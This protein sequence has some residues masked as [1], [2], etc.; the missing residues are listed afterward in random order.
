MET[1]VGS[2]GAE[3]IK[4][5]ALRYPIRCSRIEELYHDY[6]EKTGREDFVGFELT[7]LRTQIPLYQDKEL[8]KAAEKAQQDGYEYVI[9]TLKI[10]AETGYRIISIVD[11]LSDADY[12]PIIY[13]KLFG[14][15]IE[16]IEV[17]K[18]NQEK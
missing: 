9:E 10:G 4:N 6:I 16:R 5:L 3:Q 2:I 1:G 8:H 14:K 15:S 18:Y 17:Y 12:A 7:S 11:L 13:N